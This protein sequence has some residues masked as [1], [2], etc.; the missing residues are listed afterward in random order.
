MKS[1]ADQRETD[2]NLASSEKIM[3]LEK[4]V[5]EI[6]SVVL[7]ASRTLSSPLHVFIYMF[8]FFESSEYLLE[9]C[10]KDELWVSSSAVFTGWC[11]LNEF[12]S[13]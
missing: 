12:N 13:S 9:G 5:L 10:G 6:E 11:A 1:K 8:I 3:L 2:R 4:Q 7:T